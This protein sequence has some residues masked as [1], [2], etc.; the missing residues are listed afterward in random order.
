MSTLGRNGLVN[1]VRRLTG[2]PITGAR[3]VDPAA[4][5]IAGQVAKLADLNGKAVATVADNT[6]TAIVGVFASH[7]TISFYRPV[8]NESKTFDAGIVTLDHA[9]LQTGSVKVTKLD[10]TAYVITTNFTV[11]ATN[12]IIT[13]V[14]TA[15]GAAENVLVSYRYTDPNLSGIDQTLGSGKVAIIEEPGEIATLVYD[16]S[17]SYTLGDKLY[18]NAAGNITNASGTTAIGFVTKVPS[19]DNAE[20]HLKLKI[21]G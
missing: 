14:G 20:L 15:I 16:T 3:D 11:N 19:N 17:R 1:A 8:I 12:G 5:F 13:R 9:N 18:V 10:G 6:S 7:K 2:A 4:Q 21:A